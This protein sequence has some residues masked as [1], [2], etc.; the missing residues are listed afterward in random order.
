MSFS[1]NLD[2]FIFEKSFSRER[3]LC[4]KHAHYLERFL[5]RRATFQVSFTA[6]PR[7]DLPH[8][9]QVLHGSVLRVGGLGPLESGTGNCLFF[10]VVSALAEEMLMEKLGMEFS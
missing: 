1:R 3:G 4:L 2:L 6:V 7:R 5:A 8:H 10:R 9:H